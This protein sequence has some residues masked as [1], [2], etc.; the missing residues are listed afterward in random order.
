MKKQDLKELT[1]KTIKE[2]K[3]LLE[4][5]KR[6]LLSV[7]LAIQTNKEKNLKKAKAARLDIA[8]ILTIIREKQLWEEKDSKAN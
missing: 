6:D 8:Q 3:S 2:L 1:K 4:Q 5:K 7:S